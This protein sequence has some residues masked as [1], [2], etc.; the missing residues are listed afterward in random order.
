MWVAAKVGRVSLRWPTADVRWV[1][2][3][4]AILD[5]LA[6]VT[7]NVG[8]EHAGLSIVAPLGASHAIVTMALTWILIKERL[9]RLQMTGIVVTL[10]GV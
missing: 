2:I 1:V 9:S 3:G 5:S 10:A 7:Y 8:F 4:A 6:Y